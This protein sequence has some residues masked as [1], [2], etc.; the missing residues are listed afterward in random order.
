LRARKRIENN[1]DLKIIAESYKNLYLQVLE[2]P[3]GPASLLR[4]AG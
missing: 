4:Y 1:F 2:K 3:T